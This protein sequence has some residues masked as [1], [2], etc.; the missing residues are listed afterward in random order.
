MVLKVATPYWISMRHLDGL[1]QTLRLALE[2]S[3]GSNIKVWRENMGN[4]Q[5]RAALA[6]ATAATTKL[7]ITRLADE[8]LSFI[9]S[10]TVEIGKS[11]L[12]AETSAVCVLSTNVCGSERHNLLTC[13]S[14]LNLLNYCILFFL[15]V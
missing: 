3:P 7:A 1:P 6:E 8:Y 4:T 12:S 9:E 15:L 2:G 11:L 10:T 14:Q 13:H 5:G